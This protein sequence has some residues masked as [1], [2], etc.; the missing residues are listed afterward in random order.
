MNRTVPETVLGIMADTVA[1]GATFDPA[2]LTLHLFKER[3]PNINVPGD[4][5]EADA[6]GYAAAPLVA[7]VGPVA[8]DD[9]TYGYHCQVTFTG[10]GGGVANIIKGWYLTNTAGTAV[11]LWNDLDGVDS[12]N[13]VLTEVTLEL[14][15]ALDPD[16]NFGVTVHVL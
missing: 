7:W 3:D 5:T 6:S 4:F 14:V 15:L 9:G 2:D 1:A 16:G 11:R 10:A 8:F 12:L 13:G